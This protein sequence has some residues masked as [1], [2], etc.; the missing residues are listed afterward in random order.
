M[1]HN[2]KHSEFERLTI[3]MPPVLTMFPDMGSVTVTVPWPLLVVL[4][5][6]PA[7]NI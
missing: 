5:L 7:C 6:L 4:V 3:T 2:H 1:K